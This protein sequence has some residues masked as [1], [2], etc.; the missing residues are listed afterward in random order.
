[1]RGAHARARCRRARAGAGDRADSTAGG[2]LPGTVAARDRTAALRTER[3]RTPGGVA[4]GPCGT[5]AHRARHPFGDLRAATRLRTHRRRRGTRQFVQAAGRGLPLQ[6]SRRRGRARAPAR[7]P[8]R[9]R[10]RH[11]VARDP[12][13]QRPGTLPVPAPAAARG[14]GGSPAARP[15]R[16]ACARRDA[17]RFGTS[18]GG[19]PAASPG[20]GAGAGLHQPARLRADAAVH[21]LWLDGTVPVL[22]C[23]PD[24]ASRRRGAALPPL[25][26]RRAAARALRALRISGQ[27]GRPGHRAG[28]GDA[29]GAVS[30]RAAGAARSRH[31]DRSGR[32]RPG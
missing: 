19:D 10:F 25:R 7:H 11:A 12:A 31:G 32:A 22:R 20:P 28:R 21:G 23:A 16:S 17:G 5:C 4:R 26:C 8:G 14:P 13:Q 9:A 6:R 2:A 18:A 27:G 15:D 29:A 30:G 24:R 1:M 3:R